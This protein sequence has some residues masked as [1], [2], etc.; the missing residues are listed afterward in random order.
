M[1]NQ[2]CYDKMY[3]I[4]NEFW[5]AF[6]KLVGHAVSALP[7]EMEDEL[8]CRL[9]DKTS[10]Y[11]SA[12]KKHIKRTSDFSIP[13]LENVPFRF[14]VCSDCTAAQVKWEDNVATCQNCG[15]TN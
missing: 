4:E 1:N 5:H 2:D 7:P 8:L 10:V 3:H 13:E 11:G 14:W 15:K 6:S 9:S 12:Y